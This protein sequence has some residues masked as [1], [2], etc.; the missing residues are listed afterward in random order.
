MLYNTYLFP[1]AGTSR[2]QSLR[3]ERSS[4][5][6]GLVLSTFTWKMTPYRWLNPDR[7][8]LGFLREHSSEDTGKHSKFLHMNYLWPET[9]LLGCV[10]PNM[11]TY[12][13]AVA[14]LIQILTCKTQT[15]IIRHSLAENFFCFGW[16]VKFK[17]EI[18][19]KLLKKKKRLSPL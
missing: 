8:T 11:L 6:L 10:C 14:S 7:R 13:S 12:R 17:S 9:P 5:G 1:S 4:I 19:C 3:E 2:S 18:Y 15:Q 16:K